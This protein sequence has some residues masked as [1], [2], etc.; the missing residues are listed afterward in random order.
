MCKLH[1]QY[2][3]Q[4]FTTKSP[5][6]GIAYKCLLLVYVCITFINIQLHQDYSLVFIYR[7]CFYQQMKRT[8]CQRPIRYPHYI[9]LFTQFPF[10]I[11]F[12]KSL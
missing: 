9:P 5:F 2:R 6:F 12:V 8:G 3:I 1:T 11:Q 4:M 7:D 10:S